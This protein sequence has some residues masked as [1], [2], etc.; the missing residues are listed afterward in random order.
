[1]IVSRSEAE[2]RRSSWM[3]RLPRE[4]SKSRPGSDGR[5][6]DVTVDQGVSGSEECLESDGGN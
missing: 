4:V 1:M 2:E 6:G 5:S 3:E